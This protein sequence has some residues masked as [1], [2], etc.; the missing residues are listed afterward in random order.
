M[1]FCPHCGKDLSA[2]LAVEA[3]SPSAPAR[4]TYEK[5]NQDSV[6]RLLTQ[7]GEALMSSPPDPMQ[8][9]VPAVDRVKSAFV[10]RDSVSTVVH[11]FCDRDIQT[12]GGILH[13]A[14][15]L[16][17]RVEMN[18][19][20]LQRMGYAIADGKLVLVNDVPV[21]NAYMTLTY[22]GG[23]K[24][25]HRWHL[26]EPIKVEPSRNGNPFFMDERMIAFG[27]I[28]KNPDAMEAAF[29]ELHSLF[30]HGI[31]ESGCVAI[32]L[33]LEIVPHVSLA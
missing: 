26:T 6:W 1:K 32:P 7:E 22:W 20:R 9:V 10:G 30:C 27:A 19:E 17:G 24:Q 33:C 25:H 15:L 12:K 8:L 31:K 13:R 29:L 14:A 18:V 23:E 16:E 2:Y 4:A 5:Y 21:S 11:I 28:W 3:A